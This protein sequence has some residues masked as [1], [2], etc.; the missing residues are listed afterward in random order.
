M[1]LATTAGG[2]MSDETP[3]EAT[4]PND[5]TASPE[6]DT[7]SDATAEEP[8]Q[9]TP[10][11]ATAPPAA[12]KERASLQVPR[13]AAAVVA[14]A[15]LLGVGFAIGWIAAP[16]G[17]GP[18]ATQVVRPGAGGVFPGGARGGGGPLGG[19]GFPGRAAGGAFLGVEVGT[20]TGSTPGVSVAS[21]QSGSPAAQA[22]LQAGDVITAINGTAVTSPSQLS[23]DIATHQP[24]DQVTVTYTRTGVSSQAQA[25]LGSRPAPS[26]TG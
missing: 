9:P 26:S 2:L 20:A 7:P 22:G 23:Q 4:P 1:I 24:G 3:P 12:P 14:A 11:A 25:K 21:V 6:G 13:W 18:H 17:G 5:A 15:V 16:G 19:G 8:T 10:G